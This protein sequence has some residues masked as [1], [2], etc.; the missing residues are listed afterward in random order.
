[1]K[2][3]S[4]SIGQ[5]DP[6]ISPEEFRG[7]EKSVSQEWA[8]KKSAI[9]RCYALDSSNRESRPEPRGRIASDNG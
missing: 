5:K 7:S 4:E 2:E 6:R 9:E 3:V 1:M 8:D